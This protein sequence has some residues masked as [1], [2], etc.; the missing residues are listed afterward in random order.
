MPYDRSLI[1]GLGSLLAAPAI[2]RAGSL[3]PVKAFGSPWPE[4][5]L[6]TRTH[7]ITP[8][9][10]FMLDGDGRL[11]VW[12]GFEWFQGPDVSKIRHMSDRTRSRAE[13][14]IP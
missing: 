7:A 12:R 1:T 4:D 11:F 9:G 3:M 5:Q 13:P 10:H 8:G 2:V 14:S 6:L